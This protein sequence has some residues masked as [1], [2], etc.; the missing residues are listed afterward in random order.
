MKNS[1]K[2]NVLAEKYNPRQIE[3]KQQEKWHNA[4]VFEAG[5]IDKS[6]PK[7]YVLEMF[8]YPSGRIHM[9]HVRNYALGD[10]IARR[11]HTQGFQVLHPMGWDAFG[12]PAE[13]A[14]MEN[15][16]H[17][18][19]WTYE[20]IASMRNQLKSL[21]FAI[22]WTRE[23][24]TCDKEY[25]RHQQ[26]LF[27]ELFNAGLVYRKKSKVNWDP[28][29]NTVLANEQVV[30]GRGWRSGALVE[31]KELSQWFFKT[32][33][34]ADELIDALAS[35]KEWPERV[36]SQQFNWIGRS[37][38]L[39]FKFA[40]SQ[41]EIVKG[42]DDIEVYTTRPDTLFGASFVAIAADH[43]LASLVA[44][45]NSDI[46]EFVK[47]CALAAVTEEAL[48]TQE[49]RG[50]FTGLYAI[51]PFDENQK[52][53]IWIANFVLK[54]YG[55]GAVFGCPAHDQRDL[56]FANKYD[57]SVT[58]V[59]LPPQTKAEE[60]II[61]DTAYTEDGV[62]FNSQFLDGLSVDDGKRAAIDRIVSS[63]RGIEAINFRLR[64]WGVSRQRYWG[65]P[66]P[67]IHCDTC[68]AVPVPIDQLP[69]A[70]PDDV[71]F[72]RP[73]NPLD[74]H[75]SFKN[76][77]CPK[78]GKAAQRET[79][80]L[81]T[82]VD[83]SWYW[84]RFC[85]LSPDS[86]TDIEAVDH[87]LPVDH[88]I[89]G[90]EHAVLHLLYSRFFS[91]AMKK[92]GHVKVSEPFKHLFTQGMVTHATFKS[93]DGRWVYPKD[94]SFK[95]GGA[96]ETTS[97]VKIIV[98]PTEKMSKS[99]KNTIDPEFIVATYGADVARLFVLSDSPP[100]RDVEWSQAGVEGASRF[101]NRV[102]ALFA[103]YIDLLRDSSVE[104]AGGFDGDA[105][106]MLKA[107]HKAAHNVTLA[108]DGLKFNA[109]IAQL[110]ELLNV[111]RQFEN[112]KSDKIDDARAISLDI[113]LKLLQPFIPHLVEEIWENIGRDGFCVKS[114]WPQAD[115]KLVESDEV[116][117]PVQI[118]GKKRDEIL[119][120]K[121]ADQELIMKLIMETN[122]GKTYIGDRKII[123]VVYVKQRIINIVVGA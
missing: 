22:D 122:A 18:G 86:P 30:D 4:G 75:H 6:R 10:V 72:D 95:D 14:A 17:P 44:T 119:V 97:G 57:L 23:F 55:T 90:I 5:A 7:S 19:K 11:K 80:T 13:N 85:G 52:I 79:D 60:F 102:Y 118:N 76:A 91:R 101:V 70:L 63:G 77:N 29:E 53:P 16:E 111:L 66:I 114:P 36:I 115:M 59:I 58:P 47:S 1:D 2:S 67:M 98:G 121:D 54:E 49:K 41:N 109:A 73:G 112:S 117:L 26:R 61:T 62:I 106:T 28:V 82:F 123:K 33:Y 89:G 12:L 42:Y 96:F 9:G 46:A 93:E 120:A 81:D 69:V 68:G 8:P 64:D 92:T 43:D 56:D 116:L 15:G 110:Y 83:S 113:F 104:Y 32:T 34:F 48:E 105:L 37:S 27:I 84:A 20:N 3:K 107:A 74:R 40:I 24:A 108:I 99:K 78:C 39:K 65:C 21:G 50:V 38:G 88:Y 87:W 45:D 103:K 100:E 71:T 31:Q 35:L 51:H 94:V 25:Y